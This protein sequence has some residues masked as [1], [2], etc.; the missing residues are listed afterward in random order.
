VD[1][2]LDNASKRLFVNEINAIPGSLA[3]GLWQNEM[4]GFQFG[5]ALI[6]QARADYKAA[7]RHTYVFE[8]SVLSDSTVKKK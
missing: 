5:D 4:T 2:L 1:Y 8:S 3:Y 7:Q 6:S